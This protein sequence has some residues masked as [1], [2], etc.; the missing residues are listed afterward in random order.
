ML[1]HFVILS[2]SLFIASFILVLSVFRIAEVKYIYS[3]G[4]TD[5]DINAQKQTKINYELAT[6]GPILPDSVLW[7]LKAFRDRVW[8]TLTFNPLKKADVCLLFAD[9]RLASA[10][11]LFEKGKTEEA[12][13]IMTKGE[14]YLELAKIEERIAH[15]SGIDTTEFL[16]KYSLAALKHREVLDNISQNVPDNIKS[17]V[18]TAENYSKNLYKESKDNLQEEGA[19]VAQNP[20]N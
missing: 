11:I 5:S 17:A 7:P 15:D 3:R 2:T 13:S 1:K 16:Q 8:L 14:K 4:I 18:V 20:F 19:P 10:K 12:L 6:A 9:K